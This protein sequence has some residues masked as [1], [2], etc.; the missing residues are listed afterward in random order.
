MARNSKSDWHAP[1]YLSGV[2]YRGPVGKK[3]FLSQEGQNLE[4]ETLLGARAGAGKLQNLEFVTAAEY[5]QHRLNASSNMMYF[6]GTF[7]LGLADA[8]VVPEGRL[9]YGIG[10]AGKPLVAATKD[11]LAFRTAPGVISIDID[12]KSADEV[13]AIHPEGGSVIFE[14]PQQV[15]DALFDVLPEAKGHPVLVMPS[16]SSLI[17]RKSDGKVMK[18]PGGWRILLLTRDASQTPRILNTVHTRCWAHG[19]NNFAFID[20]GGSFQKRSMA[21]LALARPTQPDY[22]TSTLGEGLRKVPDTHLIKYEDAPLFDPDVVDVSIEDRWGASENLKK[23][24]GILKP[25]EVRQ[26]AVVVERAVGRLVENGVPKPDAQ[27]AVS[28]KLDRSILLGA[29]EVHFAGG[30]TV[31]V[32]DLLSSAGESYDSKVCLDP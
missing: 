4:K 20:K 1:I 17:E 16:S 22:P 29:D 3:F 32:A 2:M 31:S 19:I 8:H 15:L 5:F 11:N 13:A 21:D 14:T 6:A 18:G 9:G 7:E 28:M 25:E 27:R 30:D 10:S 24:R 23:V 26:K 12:A